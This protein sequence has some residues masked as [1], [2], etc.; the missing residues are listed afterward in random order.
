MAK[1]VP[2]RPKEPEW[3]REIE[4]KDVRAVLVAMEK[5]SDPQGREV[6]VRMLPLFGPPGQ[7]VIVN[8]QN[9]AGRTLLRV[10]EKE[11]DPT[12]R[13]AAYQTAALIGFV[14]EADIKEAVRILSVAIDQGARGGQTRYQA[15][16][17]LS[18]FGHK[19]EQSVGA[20]TGQAVGDSAYETRR[21][22]AH[23]LGR[24]AFHEHR[25]PSLKALN[26]LTTTLA[27]DP[28]AAVRMEAMQSVV[29]LGPPFQPRPETAPLL[30]DVKDPKDAPK[31]NDEA[32]K[33]LVAAVR[34]RL[35]PGKGGKTVETE[36]SVEIW[37]RLALM[38]LD[39]KE[40]NDENLNGIARFLAKTET[41]YGAKLQAL[42]AFTLMGEVAAKKIN[43]V[44]RALDDRHP[45][46]VEAALKAL[47]AMGP[48]AK[49]AIPAIEQLKTRGD[50][51]EEKE[52]YSRWADDTIKLIKMPPKP[53]PE[54][55]KK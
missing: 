24:V 31:A 37:N 16:L 2:P 27:N 21:A 25:G 42:T 30:K 3:P 52:M 15:V 20:L 35:A 26:T 41:D 38:R 7:K 17:A 51:K 8:G 29:M 34:K 33:G 46:I 55:P 11:S 47:A 36:K 32:V 10:M 45:V 6:A 4:G 48:E 50:S 28:S 44:L 13:L 5:E 9:V 19:A 22:I 1:D 53:A 54:P 14:E 49:G 18:V 43:D 39:P 40:V 23:T 12:V